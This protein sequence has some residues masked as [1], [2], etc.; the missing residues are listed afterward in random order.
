MG[1]LDG[2]RRQF[3]AQPV[4]CRYRRLGG[5]TEV[6]EVALNHAAGAHLFAEVI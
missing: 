3:G 5:D 4:R 6:P 2:L 1:A